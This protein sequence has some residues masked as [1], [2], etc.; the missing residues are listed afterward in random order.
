M[1]ATPFSAT[2]DLFY[3]LESTDGVPVYQCVDVPPA[4]ENEEF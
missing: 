3:A 2:A 1:T 4:G